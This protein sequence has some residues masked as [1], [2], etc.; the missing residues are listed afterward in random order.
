MISIPLEIT[1]RKII[2]SQKSIYIFIMILNNKY[3]NIE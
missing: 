3:L 1:Q 2:A